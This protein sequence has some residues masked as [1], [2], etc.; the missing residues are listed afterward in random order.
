M[1]GTSPLRPPSGTRSRVG[2]VLVV[3][4][5]A[6]ALAAIVAALAG[7]Y[8]IVGCQDP[9]EAVGR[10]A[11][12]ARFDVVLYDLTMRG[13]TGAELFAR[14]CAISTRQAARIVFLGGGTMPLGLAEFLSRVSNQCLQ[15]P[16][17]LA[18]LRALVFRK[19]AEEQAREGPGSA[20]T[21]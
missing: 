6:Q 3:D 20:K 2:R 16:M 21:G 5:D 17:D 13:M 11:A 19:V 8:E 1:S 7:H 14:V 15:R 10:M 18:V 12:G 4:D 9:A